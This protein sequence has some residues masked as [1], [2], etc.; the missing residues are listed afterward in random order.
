MNNHI[1]LQGK[2]ALVT[3]SSRGIGLEIVRLFS[4]LGAN[5]I[6]GVR[7]LDENISATFSEISSEYGNE[8]I[9]EVVDLSNAEFA[10]ECA[11][12]ISIQSDIGIL[13]NNAGIASGSLFQL[14]RLSEFRE[15]FEVNFFSTAVFSQTVSRKMARTGG[16]S[17]VN[18]G[19]TAGLNGD[20]GTSAYGASKAALMYLT[21]V[22]S[23][24]LGP[25]NIRVNAV[26]PTVTS[27][28]MY[29]QM[30]EN[31]R[32]A[33]INNGAL[34][35]PALPSEVADAVAF[36]ASDASSMITGQIL[37]IDGGQRGR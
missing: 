37:R 21:R 4:K 35:R 22:M 24:E 6:A 29:S 36:L 13:V 23:A 9:M 8:I 18:V 30:S 15:V 14:A 31:S 27:T 5:V 19:S 7:T 2:T 3:G 34:K 33:I 32:D 28:E 11:R 10:N 17:I 25:L 12:R 20:S 1:N 16:G 26:A